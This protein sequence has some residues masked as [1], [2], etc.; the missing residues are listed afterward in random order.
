MH[1]SRRNLASFFLF[2]VI[3]LLFS[4]CNNNNRSA[5][6]QNQIEKLVQM[7]ETTDSES[8]TGSTDDTAE[9]TQNYTVYITEWG[10]KYHRENCRYLNQS[11]IPVNINELDTKKYTPCSLCEPTAH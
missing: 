2:I 11:C 9:E 6:T 3:I 1:T 10:S 4:S 5:V 7:S 8:E